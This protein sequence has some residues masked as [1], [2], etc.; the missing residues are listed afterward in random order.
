MDETGGFLV[1]PFDLP[2]IW[3]GHASLVLE[4]KRELEERGR[5][6]PSAI[7]VR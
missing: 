4:I 2:D 6:K 1:H 7:F 5:G 3:E